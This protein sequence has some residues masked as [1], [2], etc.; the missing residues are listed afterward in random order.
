[1]DPTAIQ[2]VSAIKIDYNVHTMDNL[3]IRN[4]MAGGIEILHNDAYANAKLASSRIVNN[5]GN[6]LKQNRSRLLFFC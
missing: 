1:M 3:E 2:Y 5:L 6:C 4:C